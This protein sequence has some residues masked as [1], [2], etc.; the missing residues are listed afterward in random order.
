MI[1]CEVIMFTLLRHR[2]PAVS[3][4][5]THLVHLAFGPKS[6]FKRKCQVRTCDF[7]LGPGSGFKMRP[8]YNSGLRVICILT[9]VRSF[10]SWQI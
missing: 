2:Y 10:A 5:L 1:N 7:G 4:I 6:G 3:Q 9:D 8:V